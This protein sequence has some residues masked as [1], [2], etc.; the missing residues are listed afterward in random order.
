MYYENYSIPDSL[1]IINKLSVK[2]S[3]NMTCIHK[4]KHV[5][6]HLNN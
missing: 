3:K 2:D 5:Y 6:K 4:H 1:T